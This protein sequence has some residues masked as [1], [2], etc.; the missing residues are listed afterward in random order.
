M[1]S[2]NTLGSGCLRLSSLG[3]PNGTRGPADPA[4]ED[5]PGYGVPTA[6][7]VLRLPPSAIKVK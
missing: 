1:S 3:T 5:V 2:R 4:T 6:V 7:R